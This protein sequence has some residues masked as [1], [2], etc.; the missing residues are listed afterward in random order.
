MLELSVFCTILR[1][2]SHTSII[3]PRTNRNTFSERT[4]SCL[5]GSARVFSGMHMLALGLDHKGFCLNGL[6]SCGILVHTLIWNCV[7]LRTFAEISSYLHAFVSLFRTLYWNV[8]RK[9]GLRWFA[10]GSSNLILLPTSTVTTCHICMPACADGLCP[11][12]G[13]RKGEIAQLLT[14]PV[15]RKWQGGVPLL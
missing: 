15:I 3:H 14:W 7:N 5:A 12:I 6:A 9:A 2:S 1:T 4:V 13:A 10:I 8:F 11:G